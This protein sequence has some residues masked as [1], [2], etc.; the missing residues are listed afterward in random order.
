MLERYQ[1]VWGAELVLKPFLLGG[2][3][4]A[5]KNLPPMAR[6][7]AASQTR[8]NTE[9]L[10]RTKLHFNVQMQSMPT[11]FFGARQYPMS[12]VILR[13]APQDLADPVILPGLLGTFASCAC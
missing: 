7:W 13:S 2:V 9:D 11:N 8:W 4:A 6:P 5:T 10:T 3:M 1:S 12:V